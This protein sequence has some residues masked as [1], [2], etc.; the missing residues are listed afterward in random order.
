M[1]SVEFCFFILIFI[2]IIKSP[3]KLRCSRMTKD[4][5]I[6]QGRRLKRADALRGGQRLHTAKDLTDGVR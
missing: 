5:V 2:L 3:R 6:W 1:S 4:Y